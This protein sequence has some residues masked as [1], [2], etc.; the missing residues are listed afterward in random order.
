MMKKLISAVLFSAVLV[1]G[2]TTAALAKE[3]F[4]LG[5]GLS[6]N[7]IGGDF[8]GESVLSQG[9]EVVVVPEIDSAAGLALLVGYNFTPGFG[10]EASYYASKHDITWMGASGEAAFGTLN[11][12]LKFN[13]AASQPTQPYVLVGIGSNVVIVEDGAFDLFTGEVDDATYT[14]VGFNAG[15]GVESYLSSNFSVRAGATYRFVEYDKAKGLDEEGDIE[16]PLKGSGL[17]A[18][19][20]AAYHF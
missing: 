6:Y 7:T 12:D 2:M 17:S 18:A 3:G 14:G 16:D 19:L 1:F 5:A 11:L 10:I 20:M 9:S 8:D 13:F 4:Y 15:I